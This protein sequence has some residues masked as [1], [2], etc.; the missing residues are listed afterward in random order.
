MTD[1]DFYVKFRLEI[2]RMYAPYVL[3]ECETI[4]IEDKKN[5]NRHIAYQR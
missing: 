3:N 5:R 1:I 2:E 4:R